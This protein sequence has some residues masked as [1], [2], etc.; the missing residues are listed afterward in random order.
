MLYLFRTSATMKLHN[1]NKWWIDPKM[2]G[3]M[4][5]QAEN[6]KEALTEYQKA[7]SEKAY[8]TIS[9]N[10]IKTKNALY[11]DT[12]EG[13]AVQIGYVITGSTEFE[14]GD[15]TG[16]WVKQYI[17]LWVEILTIS[18]TEFEEEA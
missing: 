1:M 7:V 17:N 3:E 9:D 5:I 8:I 18:T 11:R 15:H 4:M 16:E 2:V 6:V 12:E 14:K 10:A 13:Q